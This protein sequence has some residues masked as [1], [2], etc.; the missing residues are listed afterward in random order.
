LTTPIEKDE[1][2]EFEVAQILPSV[3]QT[4][5]VLDPDAL[6][7]AIARQLRSLVYYEALVRPLSSLP[8]RS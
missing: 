2:T 6:L 7:P 5:S 8:S 4:E 1:P 3:A